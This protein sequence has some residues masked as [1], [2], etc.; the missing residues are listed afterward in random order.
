MKTSDGSDDNYKVAFNVRDMMYGASY[1]YSSSADYHNLDFSLPDAAS[2]MSLPVPGRVATGKV[3]IMCSSGVLDYISLVSQETGK[4]YKKTDDYEVYDFI[5][6]EG[7][8]EVRF[9][10]GEVGYVYDKII[11][12][13]RCGNVVLNTEYGFQKQNKESL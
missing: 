6:P 7:R 11:E 5:V 12:V 13:P 10:I 3:S 1:M 9:S 8:Y 2:I 4:E